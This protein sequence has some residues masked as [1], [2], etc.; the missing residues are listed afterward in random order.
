[1]CARSS[2]STTCIARACDCT[3]RGAPINVNDYIFDADSTGFQQ[4]VIDN[5]QLGPVLVHFWSR[6]A[7]PSF[8]LYP[9]LEKLVG[10]YEGAF[11][12]V[13]VDVDAQRAIASDHAVTSVPTLKLFVDGKVVETLFGFQNDKDLRFLLD[14]YVANEY[15]QVIQAALTEFNDGRVEQAYQRLGKA[16]LDNPGYYKLPLAIATLMGLEGRHEEALRLMMS[17][18]E[19]I[20]KKPACARQI[21]E[22]EFAWIAEPVKQADDLEK[23]VIE[24]PLELPAVAMLGAWYVTQ[25]QY[26]PALDYFMRIMQTDREFENGLGQRSIINILSLLKKGDPLIDRYRRQLRLMTQ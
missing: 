21:I 18:P 23:F 7:G 2:N 17:M 26:A 4:L 10:V 13:N 3:D 25:R 16:A 15:D 8:R 19:T 1:M 5:S 12:L 22:Q 6:K 24:N 9:V 20:R 14:Q 11:L